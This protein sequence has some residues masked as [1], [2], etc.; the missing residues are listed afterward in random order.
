MTKI[1]KITND[2][3]GKAY[4]GQTTKTLEQRLTQ[5]FYDSRRE[6][7]QKKFYGDIIK[8]GTDSFSIELI[9]ECPDEVADVV[10][11]YWI[12]KLDTIN[13]GY[14]SCLSYGKN[15]F[16]AKS[17]PSEKYLKQLNKNKIPLK[18]IDQFTLEGEY[19]RTFSSAREAE[20]FLFGNGH[21]AGRVSYI[22][23][24]A[25]GV[26]SKAYGYKWA[27]HDAQKAKGE[28]L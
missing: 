27:Y 20:I 1:Y 19:I 17:I 24:A 6:N 26:K 12:Y 25:R 9:E 14:N 2:K 11:S 15:S 5:H 18:A 28:E 22:Q 13:S 21:K 23:Q 4:V 7:R 16:S 10:E 8:Y 3:N